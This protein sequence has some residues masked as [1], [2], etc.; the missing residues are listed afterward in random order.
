MII[1][2]QTSDG[3]STGATRRA[4]RAGASGCRAVRVAFHR[5][6]C[7][8][9]SRQPPQAAPAHTHI[10]R[11][12]RGQ[13]RSQYVTR[14]RRTAA[15][16][17]PQLDVPQGV[18]PAQL[19]ALLNGLLQ[20]EEKLPYSFYVEEQVGPKCTRAWTPPPL[21]RRRMG[22]RIGP[23]GW[24]RAASRCVSAPAAGRACTKPMRTGAPAQRTPRPAH[25][26]ACTRACACLHRPPFPPHTLPQPTGAVRGAGGAPAQGQH[27]RRAR[28]AHHLPAAG[29]ARTRQR[30]HARS[31]RPGKPRPAAPPR[32]RP[33]PAGARQQVAGC[34]SRMQRPCR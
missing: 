25:A 28:A 19:E 2:F 23:H 10:R 4:I 3:E 34:G 6:G 18:T 7:H 13:L 33:G 12:R 24:L 1:Q 32:R 22:C 26:C 5:R 29:G 8:R 15:H 17:G 31:M 14:R 11:A 20:Q 16:A 30:P 21:L 27:Q 9:T